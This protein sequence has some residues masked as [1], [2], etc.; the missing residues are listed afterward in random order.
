MRSS[1]TV[2]EEF[3]IPF[4]FSFYDFGNGHSNKVICLARTPCYAPAD[5]SHYYGSHRAAARR[6]QNSVGEKR[7][8]G[9]S[10]RPYNIGGRRILVLSGRRGQQNRLVKTESTEEK[11]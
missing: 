4:F 2:F 10:I 9:V 3:F 5:R 8:R 6:G 1:Q 11:K 7:R